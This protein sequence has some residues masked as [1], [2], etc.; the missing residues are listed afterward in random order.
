M[1]DH[2]PI[3]PAALPTTARAACRGFAWV[4]VALGGM[5]LPACQEG[6]VAPFSL[7]D[8]AAANTARAQQPPTCVNPTDRDDLLRDML[9][10]VNAERLRHHLPPL[11]LDRTLNEIAD[12]YACRLVEGGF[13]GHVD[14]HD[15]ATM[16]AR[17]A[18]FGYAFWKVGENIAA[19]Q[20]T[21][22]QA[23]AEL[24]A[25]PAHRANLLDPTFTEIGLAVKDGGQYGRYW[26]QE[27]GRPLSAGPET[28][29][30]PLD[31]EMPTHDDTAR[32]ASQ[33]VGAS[34]MPADTTT[35]APAA[36]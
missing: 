24:L 30:R 1:P 7:G 5:V 9:Q 14:P 34:N 2:P 35:S 27:F 22:R 19:G 23:V 17:A 11:T 32:P 3:R 20:L 26:V 33:P 25:S 12:F 36:E 28:V 15:G 6:D 31:E 21:A 13:L 4:L 18:N 8:L 16:D 29:S 10:A